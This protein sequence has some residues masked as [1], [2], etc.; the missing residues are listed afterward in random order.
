MVHDIVFQSFSGN[1][2]GPSGPFRGMQGQPY[3]YNKTSKLFIFLTVFILKAKKNNVSDFSAQSE[4]HQ[5][6]LLDVKTALAVKPNQPKCTHTAS[7][8]PKAGQ[9]KQTED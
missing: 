9:K 6:G 1:P 8:K 3:F 2:G 4:S 7:Q 5:T